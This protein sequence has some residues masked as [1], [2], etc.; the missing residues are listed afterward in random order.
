ML[1]L[2]YLLE[3]LWDSKDCYRWTALVYYW[4]FI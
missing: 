1:K 4:W 3:N 2:D